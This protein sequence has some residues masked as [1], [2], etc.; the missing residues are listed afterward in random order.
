METRSSGQGF[1]PDGEKAPLGWNCFFFL[2]DLNGKSIS[3][4]GGVCVCL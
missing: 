3:G 2:L 4:G 1:L